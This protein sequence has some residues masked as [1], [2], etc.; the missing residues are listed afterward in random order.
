MVGDIKTE[1]M[2]EHDSEIEEENVLL[3]LHDNTNTNG[4]INFDINFKDDMNDWQ[5]HDI[6]SIW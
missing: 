1:I 2:H 6:Y 5:E 4:D 3:I